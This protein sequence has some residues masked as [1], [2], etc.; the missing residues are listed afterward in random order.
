M[1]ADT[2]TFA[3]SV[4]VFTHLYE[5]HLALHRLMLQASTIRWM[6]DRIGNNSPPVN[7]A[8]TVD[9]AL[10]HDISDL[11]LEEALFLA[12]QFTLLISLE[13]NYVLDYAMHHGSKQ[14]YMSH[15]VVLF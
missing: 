4:I 6:I 3:E 2:L 5:Y 13:N 10:F 11:K 7:G 14:I 12:A 8:I 1:T 15:N 9:L